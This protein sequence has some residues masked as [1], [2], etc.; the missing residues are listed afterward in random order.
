MD[1]VGRQVGVGPGVAVP[2][3]AHEHF[4]EVISG[5]VDERPSGDSVQYG[6]TYSFGKRGRR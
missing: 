4:R 6:Y 1:V 2:V 5:D 3:A